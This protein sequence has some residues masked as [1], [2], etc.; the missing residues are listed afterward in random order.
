VTPY[1]ELNAFQFKGGKGYDKRSV[2]E[3]RARTLNV[4]DDVLRANVHLE[5]RLAHQAQPVVIP[6]PSLSADEQD[7]LDRFRS[8][9][10][11]QR[12]ELLQRLEGSGDG[13][14][15][16]FA[17]DLGHWGD[18]SWAPSP[19]LL[20]AEPAAVTELSDCWNNA[21]STLSDRE[22]V[23]ATSD[24]QP[25]W[26]AEWDSV[27]P[28]DSVAST[29]HLWD[30]HEAPTAPL[31]VLPALPTDAL[32]A[33]S[34]ELF[35]TAFAGFDIAFVEPAR[36]HELHEGSQ[37]FGEDLFDALVQPLWAPPA[38]E[39]TATTMPSFMPPAQPENEVGLPIAAEVV[40]ARNEHRF[41][42]SP[43]SPDRL[44]DLFSQLDFGP[45]SLDLLPHVHA[46]GA[47]PAPYDAPMH[48]A[49]APQEDQPLPPPVRPWDGWIK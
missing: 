16:A 4:L 7:L 1:D 9:T 24:S 5:E 25:D 28:L 10:S 45:P 29:E 33:A 17:A 37:A 21:S 49:L 27:V 23:A 34:P 6:G 43:L 2:E 20:A 22:P 46:G 13:T 18:D 47:S 12:Y 32:T 38:S 44:D 40:T 31:D 42:E 3:F 14:H 26:L 35:T 30:W 36:P 8:L 39:F 48:V 19:V 15:A 11:S 41:Q